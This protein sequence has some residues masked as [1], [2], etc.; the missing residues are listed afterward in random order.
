MYHWLSRTEKII[1]KDNIKILSNSKVVVLGVG[2]VGGFAT[3]AIARSGIGTI[4]LVDKDEVDITNL[5]RQIIA[6]RSTIGQAKVEVMKRRIL[7]INPD[8]NVKTYK[9]FIGE[10]NISEIIDKDTDY[11]VDAID[12]ISSKI[13]VAVW[14]EKQNIKLISS[15][16]TGNKLDPT[17]LKISDIYK[18]SICPLAKVMRRELK[19]RN[20]KHLK[21][22]Y[23][24]EQP[25]KATIYPEEMDKRKKAPGSTA[26][27]PSV[28]GLIIASQVVR[29]LIEED[30]INER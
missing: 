28:A 9:V 17:K 24:E 2:G 13:S 4:I 6:T 20:V 30:K 15:M 22:L 7:D 25:I 18:T 11:V 26:F 27:V 23:S 29:D 3:E 5:N 14:C 21:V 19:R 1:G 8:C 10:D 12:T 16:G